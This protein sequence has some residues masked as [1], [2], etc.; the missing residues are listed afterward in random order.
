LA[1]L[2][3]AAI[4]MQTLNQVEAISAAE[5]DA[6]FLNFGAVTDKISDAKNAVTGTASKYGRRTK[7]RVGGYAG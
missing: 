5:V 6:E 3:A 1:F 7:N 4:K 2:S